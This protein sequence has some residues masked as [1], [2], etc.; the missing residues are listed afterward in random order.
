L[1]GARKL[2]WCFRPAQ[3]FRMSRG[4]IGGDKGGRQEVTTA[5]ETGGVA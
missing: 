3:I 4:G 5:A 1:K 2:S